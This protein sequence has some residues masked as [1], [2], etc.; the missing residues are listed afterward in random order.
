METE[1]PCIILDKI[2]SID[3]H[4]LSFK[5]IYSIEMSLTI[6]A[7]VYLL[8][9]LVKHWKKES[10]KHMREHILVSLRHFH[11]YKN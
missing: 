10:W 9:Y 5:R 7:G 3:K 11:T 2:F 4:S 1:P 8:I 6:F